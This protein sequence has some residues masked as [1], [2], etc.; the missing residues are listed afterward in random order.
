[1]NDS[2]MY[3]EWL[4]NFLTVPCFAEYYNISEAKAI[5]IIERGLI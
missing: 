1:M 3:L 5:S 4:N 2:E